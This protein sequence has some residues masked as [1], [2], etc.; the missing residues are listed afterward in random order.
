MKDEKPIVT[1]KL[2]QYGQDKFYLSGHLGDVTPIEKEEYDVLRYMDGFHDLL[3]ITEKTECP[4]DMVKMIYKKYKKPKKIESLYQWNK[5]G[6]CNACGVHVATEIC[7]ICGE[8]TTKIVFSPPC[9]PFIAFEE[10]R[11]FL[12]KVLHDNFQINMDGRSLFLVNNGFYQNQFFWEIE[13][14]GKLILKI[15]FCSMS[16]DGWKYTLLADKEFIEEA[17]LHIFDTIIISKY[18]QANGVRQREL[19]DQSIGLISECI[20]FFETKPLIYYSAGKESAVMLSLFERMNQE[21]NVITVATGV[22]FPEDIQFMK[23]EQERIKKIGLFKHYFYYGNE[24]DVINELNSRKVLSAKEPWCRDNFK[25]ALKSAGTNDIYEK[26]NFIACEGSRWYENDFRRRHPKVNFIKSYPQQVWI[27]P[28]AEWTSFDIWMYIYKEKI[29]QNPVYRK[30]FQRTTCWLCPITN[31]F[32]IYCSQK[33]YP[34][35][36][37]R[38]K[39]C[40]LEAF[41]D[42]R[43]GDLPY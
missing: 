15:E 43:S 9:D 21:A 42:D 23:Q 31:P 24:D 34:N 33:F 20:D 27:H 22:E 12:V 32:H 19:F 29:P 36:W 5:V 4:I 8:K 38:I 41:G 10:E 30:G 37:K 16:M 40:K 11:R 1:G 26:E 28:L 14:R 35:L 2:K 6:W 18:L 13:Y 3:Q 25:R 39:G 17:P 7:G